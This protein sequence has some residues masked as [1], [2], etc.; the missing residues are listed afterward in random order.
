M[1][2]V[3]P[4]LKWI[5]GWSR[6]WVKWQTR[7]LPPSSQHSLIVQE[8]LA[9]HPGGSW[10]R[11][12]LSWTG[13]MPPTHRTPNFW[14]E[15]LCATSTGLCFAKP[16]MNASRDLGLGVQLIFATREDMAPVVLTYSNAVENVR[17]FTSEQLGGFLE[18]TLNNWQNPELRI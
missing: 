11:V 3:D 17:E 18:D 5:R 1:G 2:K 13:P 12:I 10:H 7:K 4:R 15:Y 14:I 6:K 8:I 16:R 9:A